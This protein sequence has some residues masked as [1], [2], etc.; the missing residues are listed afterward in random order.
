MPFEILQYIGNHLHS[1]M[2]SLTVAAIGIT[3]YEARDGFFLF[4][5]KFRGKYAALVILLFAVAVISLITPIISDVW[6]QTIPQI[7][8]EQLLGIIL[9]LGMVAV[10]KAADWNL[11]DTKSIIVYS[12]GLLLIWNPQQLSIIM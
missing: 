1:I 3:I 9:I 4:N 8:L 7:P 12:L 10:N 11:F 5:D 6:R 2:T